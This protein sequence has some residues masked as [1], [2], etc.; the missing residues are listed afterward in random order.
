[1]LL[2]SSIGALP[3]GQGYERIHAD[4]VGNAE[5]FAQWPRILL[6]SPR[7]ERKRRCAPERAACRLSLLELAEQALDAA[8]SDTSHRLQRPATKDQVFGFHFQALV[9]IMMASFAPGVVRPCGRL[10]IERYYDPGDHRDSTFEADDACPGL[11]DLKGITAWAAY[12]P[13]AHA[14]E[15]SNCR[16]LELTN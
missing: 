8:S 2:P 3:P 10:M 14:L 11:A 16:I 9:L 6:S 1:M 5:A 4:V 7:R 12:L 15:L 13:L